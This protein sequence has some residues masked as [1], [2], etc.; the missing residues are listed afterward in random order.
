[1]APTI[2]LF[3]PFN[4]V[5]IATGTGQYTQNLLRALVELQDGSDSALPDLEFVAMTTEDSPN[6]VPTA[7]RDRVTVATFDQNRGAP[8]ATLFEGLDLDLVHYLI[9][10]YAQTDIPTM[11]NPLDLTHREFP[12]H[13]SRAELDRRREH[14]NRGCREATVID[15]FSQAMKEGVVAAYDVDPD[16]I[17]AVP[18]GP[19]LTAAE[20]RP[21][22]PRAEAGVEAALPDSYALFPANLWPRKNHERLL[23]ALDHVAETHGE[24]IPLVCTGT[25]D[26]PRVPDDYLVD[27]LPEEP[28]VVDMGYV[29][30]PTLRA[31]YRESRLVVYPSLYEGGGLPV[32]EAWQFDAPVVCSDIP[33][34]REKGGD[35]AAYFDPTDPAA[36]G[37]TIHAVWTDADVRETLVAR[38]RER[39]ERFTWERTARLYHALYRKTTGCDLSADDEA[40]LAYPDERDLLDQHRV[41]GSSSAGQPTGRSRRDRA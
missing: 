6:W 41:F 9:P 39:R 36:M 37:E 14:Y 17:Q 26:T 20:E 33:P 18:M 16:R 24:R 31:L 21:D 22:A 4:D 11:F 7:I 28:G 8:L 30:T 27:G 2:G 34:L 32:L 12:E 3:A 25:R 23:A 15:T 1:M 29:D 10:V 38:G 40:A 35:A 19:S 13:F 5:A